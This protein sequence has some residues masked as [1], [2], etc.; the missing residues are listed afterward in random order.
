MEFD[1]LR[2]LKN[3]NFIP[4]NILDIGAYKGEWTKSALKTFPNSNYMLFDGNYHKE[5]NDLKKTI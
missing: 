4:I 2:K 3:L 5:L 1:Y